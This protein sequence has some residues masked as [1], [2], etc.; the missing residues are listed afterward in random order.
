[1]PAVSWCSPDEG[2][3]R[4]G[5]GGVDELS[6]CAQGCG[7]ATRGHVTVTAFYSPDV[8]DG[9]RHPGHHTTHTSSES[10]IA[11]RRLT[12]PPSYFRTSPAPRPLSSPFPTVPSARR[13]SSATRTFH[14]SAFSSAHSPSLPPSSCPSLTLPVRSCRKRGRLRGI[15]RCP[16]CIGLSRRERRSLASSKVHWDW[17]WS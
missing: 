2:L 4:L 8:R 15:A 14:P 10:A 6:C 11:R 12:S 3:A 1:M 5:V 7:G 17:P 16:S 13:S 9:L